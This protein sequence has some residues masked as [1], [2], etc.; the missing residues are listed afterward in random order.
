MVA[1]AV[2]AVYVMV[3]CGV[4]R[5]VGWVA[6][7]G[8]LRWGVVVRQLVGMAVVLGHRGVAV[9]GRG[10]VVMVLV[11]PCSLALRDRWSSY[12]VGS[13]RQ[14]SL[15]GL[16]CCGTVSVVGAGEGGAVGF[17]RWTGRGVVRRG[18]AWVPPGVLRLVGGHAGG[19][20][21]LSW[22]SWPGACRGRLIPPVPAGVT[23]SG[24]AS[25]APLWG[26]PRGPC[27]MRAGPR[28]PSVRLMSPPV[29]P[30][31]RPE[32]TPRSQGASSVWGGG[33]CWVEECSEWVRCSF[34]STEGGVEPAA[35]D[36]EI[37]CY[38][39][40]CRLRPR[41]RLRS[42]CSGGR[43][44]WVWEVEVTVVEVEGEKDVAGRHVQAAP[45]VA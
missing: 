23:G 39:L 45:A 4:V 37:V 36:S 21:D 34:L 42:C 43:E 15:A 1:V 14:W 18:W 12:G 22:S 44:L 33:V 35:S 31:G 16:G 29:R 20:P 7:G 26:M 38:L 6:R 13:C 40:W 17:L 5:R 3:W 10:G 2:P 30:G 24:R 9:G 27:R 11:A 32:R 8:R 41:F 19:P 28:G 25:D